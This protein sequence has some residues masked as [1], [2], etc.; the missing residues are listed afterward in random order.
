M[1]GGCEWVHVRGPEWFAIRVPVSLRH[2]E[3]LGVA[4]SGEYHQSSSQSCEV[5]RVSDQRWSRL[6]RVGKTLKVKIRE[7]PRH[8]T[9]SRKPARSKSLG[10]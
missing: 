3:V 6:S 5:K 4:P 10:D 2:R 9:R 1:R 8:E 7:W